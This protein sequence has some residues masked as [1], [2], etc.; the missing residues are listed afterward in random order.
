[1]ATHTERKYDVEMIRDF[2]D[3]VRFELCGLSFRGEDRGAQSLQGHIEELSKK[4]GMDCLLFPLDMNQ[5]QSE[6][7]R[8]CLSVLQGEAAENAVRA[9]EGLQVIFDEAF[10]S[11]RAQAKLD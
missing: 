2:L 1:M 10:R 3:H 5:R 7:N 9:L 4:Y 11:I 6:R 8:D